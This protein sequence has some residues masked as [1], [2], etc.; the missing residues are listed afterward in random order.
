MRSIVKKKKG[1]IFQIFFVIALALVVAVVGLICL[2]ITTRINTFYETS[3]I[4]NNSASAQDAVNKMQETAPYT[5]DYAIFFLFLGM[6]IGV[7]IGAVRTNF[8]VLT[9]VIF[10][11]LTLIAI[12]FAAGAVNMYQGL[13]QTES[14]VDVSSQLTLTNFIFSKYTP[15]MISIICAFVMLIMY[16]KSGADITT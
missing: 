12:M 14:I 8:S 4:L 5:T 9:I 7:I 15:L 2:V 10:I 6:N 3:G 16:S 11:F 1:D 13:A